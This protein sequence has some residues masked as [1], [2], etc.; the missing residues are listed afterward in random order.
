MI[1]RILSALFARFRRKRPSV[2]EVIERELWAAAQG[3]YVRTGDL[4]FLI[5][6]NFAAPSNPTNNL[7]DRLR[8]VDGDYGDTK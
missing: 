2:D 5:I 3:H 8:R 1:R 4:P 6:D 7:P